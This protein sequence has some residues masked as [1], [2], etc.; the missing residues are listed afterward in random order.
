L[1]DSAR[2]FHRLDDFD[3]DAFGPSPQQTRETR[4]AVIGAQLAGQR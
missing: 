4:D 2:D 1:N 3:A